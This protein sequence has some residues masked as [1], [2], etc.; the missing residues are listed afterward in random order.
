VN[1]RI[2]STVNRVEF[3]SD[4]ISYIILGGP[5]YHINALNV[6]APMEDKT[7]DMK[8]SFYQKFE[9]VFD[10]FPKYHV[11]SL[12]YDFYAK[13][14]KEDSLKPIIGNASINKISNNKL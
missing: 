1:K 2:I 14:D 10:G 3:V 6:H 11:K 7:D 5:W 13:V 12:L 9:R 4:R 8:E